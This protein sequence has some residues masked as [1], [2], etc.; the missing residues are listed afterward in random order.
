MSVETEGLSHLFNWMVLSGV[1]KFSA[2]FRAVSC[3][4]QFFRFPI[5]EWTWSSWRF[6]W[7]DRGGGRK[8]NRLKTPT[9]IIDEGSVLIS[10]PSCSSTLRNS[11][12]LTFKHKFDQSLYIEFVLMCTRP[13]LYPSLSWFEKW[14][15]VKTTTSESMVWLNQNQ[16]PVEWSYGG[17]E[18]TE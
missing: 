2:A 8:C 6:D 5:S 9:P 12:N 11:L 7:V 3:T 4:G 15:F 1:G 17:K 18:N 13:S 14:G 16:L 10:V